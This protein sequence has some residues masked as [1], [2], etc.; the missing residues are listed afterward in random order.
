MSKRRLIP[1]FLLVLAIFLLFRVVPMASEWKASL[2]TDIDRLADRRDQLER[3][4]ERREELRG[5]LE[6][7]ASSQITIGARSLPGG[8]P[9]VASARLQSLLRNYADEAGV[10]V[11]SLSLPEIE[12]V[13]S[14][15]LLQVVVTMRGAEAAVLGF[16]KR[17]E[18]DRKLLRVVGFEMRDEGPN[19]IGSATVVGFSPLAAKPKDNADG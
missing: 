18:S 12:V 5:R 10:E 4:L 11:S 6:K 15:R 7:L 8:R 14:W 16:L 2:G 17:V 3:L 19:L 1:L 13:G 9:E